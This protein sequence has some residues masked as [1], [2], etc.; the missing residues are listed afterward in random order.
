MIGLYLVDWS[1]IYAVGEFLVGPLITTN[2]PAMI[3]LD[4]MCLSSSDFIIKVSRVMKRGPENLPTPCYPDTLNNICKVY[5]FIKNHGYL[6][7]CRQP[8]NHALTTFCISC[9]MG[10]RGKEEVGINVPSNLQPCIY[11]PPDTNTLG[12]SKYWLNILCTAL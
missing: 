4:Q 6:K 12:A 9:K 11:A 8:C 5:T 10:W 3:Q 7:I 2:Q 1:G